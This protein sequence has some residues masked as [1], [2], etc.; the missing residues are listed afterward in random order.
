MKKKEL[1]KL[2]REELLEMLLYNSP[3]DYP[4]ASA[5][6]RELKEER[7][8]NRY[9]AMIKSTAAALITAAAVAVLVAELWLP[10]L[11]IYGSS[12]TPTLT[13]GDTVLSVKS[14]DF[15]CGDIVAFYYGSRLLVKRC[16]AG[17]GDW[18]TID[19]EGNV[20]INGKFLEEP[21]LKEKALGETDLVYP[22]QVPEDKYFVLGD[23]RSVS[24]DSR[25]SQIG[26][27]AAEQI[28]GKIVFRLWPFRSFGKIEGTGYEQK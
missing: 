12:M 26:C 2:N 27:V 3:E 4:P 14:R 20:F 11:K 24:A 21:Y 28:V 5:L 16:I 8:R 25:T 17:P 15:S 18:V 23:H 19:S 9:K 10:V 1:K 7:Y 22:F 6:L 13:N